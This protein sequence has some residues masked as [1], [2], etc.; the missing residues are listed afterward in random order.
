MT[1]PTFYNTGTVSVTSGGTSITGVGTAWGGDVILPGD[2]FMDPAQPEV[3]PQRIAAVSGN[4]SATLAHA[5][6]GASMSADAYEIRF[7]GDVPRATAQTRRYL[8]LLGQVA[9]TGIGIDAFGDFAS[10]DGYDTQP[11][12]YAYLSLDGDGGTITDAV[13]FLKASATSGDWS[14]PIEFVG[15]QGATGATGPTGSTGATGTTGAAG[16]DGTDPGVLMTWST[17]TTDANPG[18][19]KIRANNA[20]LGSATELYISKTGRGGTSIANW[21]ATFDDSTNAVKGDLVITDPASEA[22]ALYQVT[23][24]TDATGYVKIA[25][26]THSGATGFADA[27]A[28]SVQFARAGNKGTDGTGTGDVVGPSSAVNNRAAAFDGTTG[29]LLKDSGIVLGTAAAANTGTSAG[30]VP[31]L[32]GGGKLDSALLPAVAISDIF[33]VASEAAMLALTAEKGDIAIRTDLN[34]SFALSTNSPSTLADWKE[35]LT[36]TDAVLAVAG[37]TGSISASALKTAL[38]IGQSDVSGLT[39]SDSP[40]FTGLNIGHISDTTI[41]RASAGRVNVEGAPVLLGSVEGQSVSGG[42]NVTQKDLG[43]LSGASITPNP[44]NRSI[45]K[46]TN[47]GA[48]SILPGTNYGQYTLAIINTTGAGAITTTGW[49]VKGDSFDT[50]TTSKFLCSCIVTPDLSLMTVLKVA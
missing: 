25:V 5:W 10:R 46:V 6:P 27:L 14:D 15:P 24:L 26:S 36:P 22:Q 23:G 21:L 38:A 37:L 45:Q 7:S 34:K 40:W 49:T 35:L 31:V 19:G 44:G 20:A 48:G 11:A 3:P 1:L 33:T 16:A 4:G 39:P 47:N 2:L 28:V 32:D 18:T 17:T 42:A 12:G 13:I 50:T 8:E 43:N 29:K 30:N 41:T 9:N